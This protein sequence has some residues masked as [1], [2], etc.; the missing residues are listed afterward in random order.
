[1]RNKLYF[2]G[3]ARPTN[4]GPA[5]YACV[6]YVP[7]GDVVQKANV[8]GW[9][10]N[11]FAEYTGLVVGLKLAV[12]YLGFARELDVYTDSQIVWGHI[13]QGWQRNVDELKM[14]ARDADKL[15]KKHWFDDDTGEAHWFMHHIPRTKNTLADDLC[16]R[17][18]KQSR[19]EDPNP[20]SV[21]A[22][23]R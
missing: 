23:I 21:K 18:I 12:E 10:T 17:A 15:L 19:E 3:G 1:M 7:N 14:L 22:G 11:N 20:F 9:H 16:T 4:P 5:G 6:L 8:I 13:T 2:D